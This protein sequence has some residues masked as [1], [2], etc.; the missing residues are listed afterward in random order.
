MPGGRVDRGVLSS[1]Y[2]EPGQTYLDTKTEGAFEVIAQQVDSNWDDYNIVKTNLAS[3]AVGASGAHSVKSAP[4]AGVDGAN[5]YDQL[6]ALKAQINQGV[7]SQ[8]PDGSLPET[9][10]AFSVATQAELDAATVGS[11]LYMY[12]NYGGF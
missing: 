5:V 3:T 6:F 1:N 8:I 9:K 11:K 10:L 4:I 7:L 2:Q 12:K